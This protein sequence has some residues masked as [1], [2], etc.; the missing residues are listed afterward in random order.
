MNA[1][2]TPQNTPSSLITREA[3]ASAPP[4]NSDNPRKRR[5]Y[6]PGGLGGGGRWIEEEILPGESM[7]LPARPQT[8]RRRRNPNTPLGRPR[9]QRTPADKTP[10]P[11]GAQPTY[12]SAADAAAAVQNDGYKPR[13]ER[14][15]EEF[16]PD[17]E[18]DTKLVMFTAVEVDG[19]MAEEQ[20]ENDTEHALAGVIDGFENSPAASQPNGVLPDIDTPQS[21]FKKRPGRPFRRPEAMLSGLGLASPPT[22]KIA[23]LPTQ[24][25]KERLSLAKPSYRIV[26]IFDT[27]EADKNVQDN[28]VT[29]SMKNVGYQESDKF[30]RPPHL[31]RLDQDALEDDMED[32]L[33]LESDVDANGGAASASVS[34]V[35]YDMDEQDGQWLDAH[36]Q[37]RRDHESVDAIKPAIFEITMTQIEKEWHAL[38]K[39]KCVS[40]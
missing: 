7:Q 35:E 9:R 25:P 39:S 32:G 2:S 34:K 26:K 23:P 19:I 17:L 14:G 15:W 10:K 30:E 40:F 38:E 24:N 21:S 8:E 1:V 20:R 22:Q 12:H 27:F 18:L 31:I 3:P 13:E 6:I 28:Y 11:M 16:H 5:R 29:Q 37:Q 4:F 33:R 36:N